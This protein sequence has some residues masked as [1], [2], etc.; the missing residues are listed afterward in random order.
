MMTGFAESPWKVTEDLGNI[1]C[2]VWLLKLKCLRSDKIVPQSP[3][4][5]CY[6]SVRHSPRDSM[7]LGRRRV[8]RT[9]VR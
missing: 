8:V 5:V 6:K 2:P 3:R 4:N 9:V 1:C 7:K